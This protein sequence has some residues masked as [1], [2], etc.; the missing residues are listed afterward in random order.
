MT[1]PDVSRFIEANQACFRVQVSG[2]GPA[3]LVLLHELGGTLE[4]WDGLMPL[5][6]GRRRILRFDMRGAG[7][8]EK[9]RGT[10]RLEIL[11]QDV[12]CI[13][14]T[15]GIEGPVC[16]AGAAAGAAI[17]MQFAAKYPERTCG[18]IA[19]APA[20]G[21]PESARVARFAIADLVEA[22][23]MRSRVDASMENGYPA[24]MRN[25]AATFDQYRNRWIGNDP[26]SY[27]AIHR[28]LAQLDLTSVLPNIGCPVLVIAGSRDPNRTP[29]DIEVVMRPLA[30][31]RLVTID[32]GHFMAVLTPELVAEKMR[33]FLS[34]I[35]S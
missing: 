7:M 22:S 5:L 3:A 6:G 14:D 26:A 11:A 1:K 28:M 25:N 33:V 4:S 20:A 32:S 17:A 16:V 27:A 19:M 23:G 15:L 30:T 21:V 2:E 34:E 10:V 9:V 8:S 35:R 13:L 24:S 18:L 31:K 29:Q 12:A